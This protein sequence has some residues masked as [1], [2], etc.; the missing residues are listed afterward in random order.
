MHV[1][2]VIKVS[3]RYLHYIFRPPY[4]WTINLAC[5]NLV[6]NIWSL[7]EWRDLKLGEVPSWLIFYSTAISGVYPL[8]SFPFPLHDNETI[9]RIALDTAV[10][11]TF[12]H[13]LPTTKISYRAAT[14]LCSWCI[15]N[16]ISLSWIKKGRGWKR[17]WQKKEIC[18]YLRRLAFAEYPGFHSF[19]MQSGIFFSC[20]QFMNYVTII[21]FAVIFCNVVL[22]GSGFFV[23]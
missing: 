1:K 15:T 20:K 19:E 7:R 10:N 8:N 13:Q 12:F 5:T 3:F 22:F 21:N 6:T 4:W 17:A 18:M 14:G 16:N 23:K 2:I 11:S 9:C